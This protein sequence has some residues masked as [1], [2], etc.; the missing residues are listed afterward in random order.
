MTELD[1]SNV[2]IASDC[3]F[4]LVIHVVWG[5]LWV[6]HRFLVEKHQEARHRVRSL[7]EPDTDCLAHVKQLVVLE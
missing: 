3:K 5:N 2:L 7:S 1:I 4:D 6:T